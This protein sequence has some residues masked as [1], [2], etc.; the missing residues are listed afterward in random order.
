M[1]GLFHFSIHC[2]E[3]VVL[4]FLTLLTLPILF[5]LVEIIGGR[6]KSVAQWVVSYVRVPRVILKL[7]LLLCFYLNL[8]ILIMLGAGWLF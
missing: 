7:R 1:I 8:F 2:Y 4:L 5:L 3:L 6:L